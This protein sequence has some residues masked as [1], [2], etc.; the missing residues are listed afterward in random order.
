MNPSSG[1]RPALSISRAKCC[2]PASS[3]GTSIRSSGRP[4][5]AARTCNRDREDVLAGLKAYRDK[6]GKA[7]IVRGFGWRYGAFP[8]TGPRK[9]DLDAIWPDTP[10]FLIAIDAHS[11][12]V[13]SQMLALAGVTKDTKDPIP[14][15]S[16]FE[17]DPATGE[18]TGYLVEVPAMMMVNNAVEPF[19][20]DYVAD[21]LAEWLP[22]A[23]EAGITTLFDAG[24]QIVPETEGFA[25]YDRLEREGKLPFRVIGSYYHNNP[26]SIPSR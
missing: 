12:W 8:A 15:F 6:V 23:S 13:N 22:K 26:T 4:S 20:A 5:R 7:D 24:M 18:P 2:F 11:A 9:E 3:K 19:S 21:S 14:G 25:I 16:T 10:V 17:R 1:R